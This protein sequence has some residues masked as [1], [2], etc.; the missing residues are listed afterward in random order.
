MAYNIGLISVIHQHELT[1]G[2]HMSLLSWLSLPPPAHPHPSRLL[3]WC[4]KRLKA[5]GEGDD[6]EWDGW[7]ASPT[8]WTWVWVNSGSWH[9][10]GMPGVLQ[11]MG[12]Q[13]IGYNWETELNW[14]ERYTHFK[15]KDLCML[16]VKWRRKL[17]YTHSK[18]KRARMVVL[19]SE[20]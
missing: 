8:Q 10:T 20:K 7:M 3:P 1:I 16:N 12:L 4:W 5:G 18:G 11:Y 14:I 9:W 19:I 6:R 17:Y 2:A 15:Y 13:R